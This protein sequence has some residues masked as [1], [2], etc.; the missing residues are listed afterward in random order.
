MAFLYSLAPNGV[1]PPKRLLVWRCALAAPFHHYPLPN[2]DRW[3]Y[4]SV[5]LSVRSP[6]PDVIRHFSRKS[7]DFPLLQ[8]SSGCPPHF[9]LLNAIAARFSLSNR[10]KSL[11]GQRISFSV[12]LAHDMYHFK[13]SKKSRQASGY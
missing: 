13:R 11:V 3:L 12:L 5:A 8:R 7:P 2:K 1:Y 4:V 9:N 10:S 6:S